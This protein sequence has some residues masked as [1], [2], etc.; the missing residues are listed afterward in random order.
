MEWLC[1]GGLSFASRHLA[2]DTRGRQAPLEAIVTKNR[3]GPG[4]SPCWSCDVFRPLFG[5]IVDGREDS[6]DTHRRRPPEGTTNLQLRR[7]WP[8]RPR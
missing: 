1:G 2:R 8:I 7:P 3:R 4:S 5:S 6:M